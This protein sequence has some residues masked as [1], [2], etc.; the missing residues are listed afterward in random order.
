M[1][2]VH[3]YQSDDQFI[4]EHL[5]GTSRTF[6]LAIPLLAIER[7]QQI[8]L[9]YL[10]FRVADSIEDAPEGDSLLKKQLLNRLK[11]YFSRHDGSQPEE[12]ASEFTSSDRKSSG[13]TD[14]TTPALACFGGLWSAESP[15][16][17][18]LLE[19]PRLLSIFDKQ[20]P[21]VS[22]VIGNALTSTIT[23]MIRFIDASRD[24]PN[25]IQIQTVN[26]LRLYC[27]AVAGIVGELL[28]DIFIIHH[29]AGLVDHQELRTLSVGFGE[30]LQ[31]INILKDAG[32]DA[33]N[34]R[35]FIPVEVSR[36]TIYELAMSGQSDALMY[37]RLLEKNDFPR[38]IIFYCRFLYLLAEGS[39]RKLR[40]GGT[41]S[42]LTRDEVIRLLSVVQSE[43]C[44]LPI[45]DSSVSGSSGIKLNAG[46]AGLG[47]HRG[48]H[49]P[50]PDVSP[51][52][53]V[54]THIVPQ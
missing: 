17:R 54:E 35:V 18:L 29:P 15:T 53:P 52:R 6:A 27:Y 7:R 10:L 33:M 8:G 9:S 12:S 34:G 22:Q 16:G 20:P 25:Q 3:Q 1:T 40:E 50:V 2:A 48:P 43:S 47:E 30:F 38:D 39:L 5:Q 13:H 49:L 45:P 31:L 19:F 41:G 28:T 14:L 36:E 51:V 37:I 11:N 4:G 26:D 21:N 42:K 23:G 44:V 24:F 32:R 46:H